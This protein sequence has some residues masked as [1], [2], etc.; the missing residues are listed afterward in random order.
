MDI[1]VSAVNYIRRNGLAHRQFQQFLLEI[2]AEYGDVLY[3]TEVKWL[4]KGT[5]LKRLFNLKTEIDI[6]M[7]E[8]RKTIPQLSDPKWI[9]ELAFFC[10]H[11]VFIN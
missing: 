10:G 7:T 9:L 11:N 1:V 8:K 2:E 4:S 3:Y 5:V 6:F